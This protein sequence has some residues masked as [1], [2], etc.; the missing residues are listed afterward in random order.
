MSV[1][2]RS[3]N[4]YLIATLIIGSSLYLRPLAAELLLPLR[5]VA[6]PVPLAPGPSCTDA[7]NS[8]YNPHRSPH[9]PG[10]AEPW[11]E[12]GM[13]R[14]SVALSTSGRRSL[15]SRSGANQGATL[16]QTLAPGHWLLPL[17]GNCQ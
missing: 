14:H 6:D 16:G 7:N 3:R 8:A 12:V 1:T 15:R 13:C 17:R 4:M 11:F 5:H 2:R 9:E 10:S